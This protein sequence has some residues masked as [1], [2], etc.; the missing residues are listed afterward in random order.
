MPHLHG[1]LC[2]ADLLAEKLLGALLL[3][4][5]KKK[6]RQTTT[7]CYLARKNTTNIVDNIST[8]ATLL[9]F[10][11]MRLAPFHDFYHSS[12][13]NFYTCFC[14]SMKILF[15]NFSIH[16][17]VLWLQAVLHGRLGRLT[18]LPKYASFSLKRQVF[19]LGLLIRSRFPLTLSLMG[20]GK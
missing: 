5:R 1:T 7:R 12:F 16:R 18:N 19:W 10:S 11:S 17:L 8:L 15:L 13:I 20:N 6:P 4:N 14:L 9:S 2:Q 3:E